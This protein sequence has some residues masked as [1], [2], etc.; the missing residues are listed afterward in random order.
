[1]G[2]YIAK[3]VVDSYRD[4]TIGLIPTYNNGFGIKVLFKLNN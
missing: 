4:A 3:S 2:L 1:M